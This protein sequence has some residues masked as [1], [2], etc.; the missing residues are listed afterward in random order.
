[1]N[2]DKNEANYHT[3]I[4]TEKKPTD[5]FKFESNFD[6]EL[7]TK[8]GKDSVFIQYIHGAGAAVDDFNQ[9]LDFV[10]K[11]F[12]DLGTTTF[13]IKRLKHE[14]IGNLVIMS[15]KNPNAIKNRIFFGRKATSS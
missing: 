8:Y 14:E 9:C 12:Y 15:W 3:L 11:N 4:I 2:P 10:A 1:L 7:R 5:P 13:T 6:H